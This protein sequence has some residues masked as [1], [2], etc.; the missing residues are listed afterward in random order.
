MPTD[1]VAHAFMELT[2]SRYRL[3]CF[4]NN[5]IHVIAHI[6]QGIHG[7]Y[8]YTTIPT[9]ATS[10]DVPS[11]VADIDCTIHHTRCYNTGKIGFNLEIQAIGMRIVFPITTFASG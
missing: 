5:E 8:I 1:N 4:R 2:F 10:H 11:T 3:Q 9:V 6:S 7:R